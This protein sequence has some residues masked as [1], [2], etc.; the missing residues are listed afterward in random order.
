MVDIFYFDRKAN[1]ISYTFECEIFE[2]LQDVANTTSDWDNQGWVD[3][4]DIRVYDGNTEVVLADEFMPTKGE[5]LREWEI[6]KDMNSV[7]GWLC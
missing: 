5:V 7:E 3:I 2:K 1:G 4:H 6:C